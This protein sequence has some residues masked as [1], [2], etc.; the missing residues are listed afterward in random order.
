M[1]FIV[2]SWFR[3]TFDISHPPTENSLPNDLRLL[4]VFSLLAKTCSRSVSLMPKNFAKV[5]TSFPLLTEWMRWLFLVIKY[6]IPK[7]WFT[8]RTPN[9]F[10]GSYGQ[11]SLKLAITR[12]NQG[13][14]EFDFFE[15]YAFIIP[16]LTSTLV[17]GLNYFVIITHPLH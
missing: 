4:R 17:L 8:S 10:C 2:Y 13:Y 6:E 14:W 11:R 9:N 1:K 12:R 3:A 7:Y 15:L 16:V 5:R